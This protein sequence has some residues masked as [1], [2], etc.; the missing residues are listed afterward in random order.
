MVTLNV[1][2][3]LCCVYDLYA[4]FTMLHEMCGVRGVFTGANLAVQVLEVYMWTRCVRAPGEVGVNYVRARRIESM[5]LRP[6]SL[7]GTVLVL[8]DQRAKSCNLYVENGAWLSVRA[9]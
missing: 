2:G 4:F 5:G 6:L 9:K 7:H 8:A 1:V 3:L